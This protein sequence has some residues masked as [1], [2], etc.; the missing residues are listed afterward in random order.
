M[1]TAKQT[2]T[3][4]LKEAGISINGD[5]AYDIQINNERFYNRVLA[6]GVLGLG[7]SYMDGDWD[8]KALDEMFYRALRA[9]LESK[10]FSG[11]S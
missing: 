1:K 5:Q 9:G 8:C 3:E 11:S 6:E 2:I 7:E 10:V 4:I